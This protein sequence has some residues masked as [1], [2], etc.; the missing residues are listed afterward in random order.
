LLD[1]PTAKANCYK[2]SHSRRLSWKCIYS[3]YGPKIGCHGNTLLPL[4]YGS[5]TDEF[6]I[7]QTL[8]QNRTLHGYVTHNWN[9]GNF[10]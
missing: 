9:C 4:V 1:W 2:Q 8:S 10:V 6:P 7:A 3:N 5:V